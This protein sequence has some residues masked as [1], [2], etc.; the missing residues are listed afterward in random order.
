MNYRFPTLSQTFAGRKILV[1]G[2]TGFKGTWLTLWLN[3][4]GSD[5]TGFSNEFFTEPSMYIDLDMKSKIN[6]IH[7]DICDQDS[8]IQALKSTKPDFVF[9]LAAQSLVSES[10]IN[11]LETLKTNAIGT[12]TLLD[13]MLKTDFSGIAVMITSDKCYE[14]DER[15]VGYMESDRLGGW[16][17]Y[18]ASKAGAEIFLSSYVRSFFNDSTSAKIGIARA[19]N[20]IGGGDWNKNRIIVDC[21]R[22]WLKRE[23]VSIRNPTATRPWQHVLEPISGY[24]KLAQMLSLNPTLH[25]EAFNFGPIDSSTHTVLEVVNQ[26]GAKWGFEDMENLIEINDQ[27]L[28]HEA[29]LLKLNCEKASLHLNWNPRLNLDECLELVARWYLGFKENPENL[30]NLTLEQISYFESKGN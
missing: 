17:P 9:H 12:A 10:Y 11:P 20:V 19:G 5:V 14:N 8:I 1:T 30:L 23:K 15:E 22:S 21:V 13:S 24:L 28:M 18:S 26:F 25:G 6:Q 3:K 7:G 2:N 4:I 27:R 16:D 29:S